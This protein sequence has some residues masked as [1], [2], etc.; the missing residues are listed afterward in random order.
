[1]VVSA[2]IENHQYAFCGGGYIRLLPV[3]LKQYTFG[4]DDEYNIMFGPDL[5]GYDVSHVHAIF[6]NKGDNLLT[7]DKIGCGGNIV[8][9]GSPPSAFTIEYKEGMDA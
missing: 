3:G 4:G 6:N 2:K 5:C 1:M 8:P 9:T 7:T